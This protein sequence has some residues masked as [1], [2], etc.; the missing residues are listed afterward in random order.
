MIISV[1]RFGDAILLGK[2]LEPMRSL[3]TGQRFDKAD[4][5]LTLYNEMFIKV[6]FK[7]EDSSK[8]YAQLIPL[9][10]IDTCLFAEAP[11]GNAESS[12]KKSRV[13]TA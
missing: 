13:K 5:E 6:S 10:R 7:H 2:S 9:A 1:I 8:D 11:V 4:L 12:P 3:S